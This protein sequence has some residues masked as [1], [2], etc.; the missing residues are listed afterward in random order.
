MEKI[1]RQES[2]AMT[3]GF[4]ST[5]NGGIDI[6][7]QAFKNQLLAVESRKVLNSAGRCA[8]I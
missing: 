3:Y 1:R 7:W 5:K 2:L 6:Y 4:F 8:R